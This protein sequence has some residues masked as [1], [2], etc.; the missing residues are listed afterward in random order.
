M[1]LE[2]HAEVRGVGG[3]FFVMTEVGWGAVVE[4]YGRIV[5]SDKFV[6]GVFFDPGQEALA[7]IVEHLERTDF[8]FCIPHDAKGVGTVFAVGRPL[9]H[10][11][12]VQRG[13]RTRHSGAEDAGGLAGDG[14]GAVGISQI[15][16]KGQ[17]E[18][19][20]GTGGA[21]SQ[22]D[23]GFVEVP[24]LGLAAA[25]LEGAGAIEHRSLHG[26][27]ESIGGG[28]LD[29]AVFHGCHRDAGLQRGQDH[30]ASHR[31]VAALPAATVDVNEQRRGLLGLRPPK[32]N[33]LHP[34]RAIRDVFIRL[35]R[36]FILP[37]LGCGLLS[38]G[39]DIGGVECGQR[40]EEKGSEKGEFHGLGAELLR[41]AVF[42]M[43]D[44]SQRHLDAADEHTAHIEFAVQN[45][46]VSTFAHFEASSVLEEW[47]SR[48]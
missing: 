33:H 20:A 11:V 9:A 13:L 14:I 39:R 12:W 1:L 6:G 7:G 29:G 28:V 34:M 18:A 2:F 19:R 44:K 4:A 31:P 38:L 5:A 10:L 3:V 27:H 36:Q 37:V 32:V 23:L 40:R 22:G 46:H 26:W 16:M 45:H 15:I 21:A 8:L 41:Y 43:Q 25:E 48:W 24:V 47:P 42:S 35:D 17:P 30:A